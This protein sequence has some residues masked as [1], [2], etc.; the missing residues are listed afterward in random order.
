MQGL[1]VDVGVVEHGFRGNTSDVETRSAKSATFLNASR[2]GIT[3][4]N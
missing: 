1:V 2:L 4:V 3:V